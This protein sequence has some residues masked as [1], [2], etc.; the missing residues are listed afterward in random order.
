M[1][2][3]PDVGVPVGVVWAL[4]SALWMS[5]VV[6]GLLVASRATLLAALAERIRRETPAP[7]REPAKVRARRPMG[8]RPPAAPP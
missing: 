8:F 4:V 1:T 3:C 6:S 5:L 7:R 2:Q